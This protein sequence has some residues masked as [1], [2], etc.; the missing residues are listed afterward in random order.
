[1]SYNENPIEKDTETLDFTDSFINAVGKD[2][3]D[4][5][6]KIMTWLSQKGYQKPVLFGGALRDLYIGERFPK[7][8]DVEVSRL[9]FQNGSETD[10]IVQR[11][12]S[13][14]TSLLLDLTNRFKD[15]FRHKTQVR[16]LRSDAP[17][18]AIAMNETGKIL[19]HPRFE[20][21]ASNKIFR[22]REDLDAPLQSQSITRFFKLR[23]VYPDLT[24]DEATNARHPQ[25]EASLQKRYG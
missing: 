17:I 9:R 2:K 5:L 11:L 25:I 1:M 3:Y 18:S 8:Y 14:N 21:D 16:V 20:A 12:G 6:F 7:D 10:R 19:A 4:S 13:G 23:A 15:N 24:L 22:I